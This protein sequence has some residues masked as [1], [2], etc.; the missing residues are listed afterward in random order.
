MIF[1]Q[2]E[3]DL[4]PDRFFVVTYKLKSQTNL[5]DAAWNL[6]CGQ[7]LGNPNVRSSWETEEMFEKHLARIIGDE[8]YF[9]EKQEGIVRIAFPACNIDWETD[10]ITQLLVYIM[11]G[12]LDID[13]IT[14]CQVLNIN[15]PDSVLKHFKGPKFGINK[16]REFTNVYNKPLLGGIVK[17]KTGF[18]T[19]LLLSMIG[20][21]V[22]GGVN[23]IKEDEL[24]ANIPTSPLKER[25]PLVCDFLR[26]NAPDVIYCFCINGDGTHVLD[27]VRMVHE[28]GGNGVH[29]NFWNGMG[30]YKA[31]R[32]MDLPIHV[33]FQKS[34]D[35]IITHTDHNFSIDFRVIAELAALSGID[36]IHAGM[37]GGY[38]SDDQHSLNNLMRG[39]NSLEVIPALSCGMHPGLVNTIT[40][41]F[42]KNYLANVGGCMHGHP[43]GTKAGAKAMRDAIDGNLRSKEY[44]EAIDKWGRI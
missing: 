3:R 40:Q 8:E 7:S 38:S 30:V 24:A 4:E 17:P 43:G 25:I 32:D 19:Q 34:G 10:G 26:K 39:L 11:G 18:S 1:M 41:K 15:F 27:R 42:G 12:Q 33:H 16:V 22:E 6:A 44:L 31:I 35:K 36:F 13:N 21:M 37:W 28:Y 29:V 2:S 23:F 14:H 5:R 9:K 20:E